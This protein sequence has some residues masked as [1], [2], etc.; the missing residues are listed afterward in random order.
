MD[1]VPSRSITYAHGPKLR[2][3]LHHRYIDDERGLG[4]LHLN[5]DNTSRYRYP[6]QKKRRGHR[7]WSTQRA[8]LFAFC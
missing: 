1:D 6:I 7:E 4:E 5:Y 2:R 3:L 8:S